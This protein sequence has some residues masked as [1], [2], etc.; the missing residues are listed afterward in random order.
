MTRSKP[1]GKILT[2]HKSAHYGK[3]IFQ[4]E[5]PKL[6]VQILFTPFVLTPSIFILPI[7]LSIKPNIDEQRNFC[8]KT[9]KYYSA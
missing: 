2:F 7:L 6:N 4:K 5:F 9:L 8:S 3:F 1:P